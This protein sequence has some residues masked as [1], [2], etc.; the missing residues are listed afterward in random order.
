ML[1]KLTLIGVLGDNRTEI[2]RG[3]NKD[4]KQCYINS[5]VDEAHISDPSSCAE[6]LYNDHHKGPQYASVGR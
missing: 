1:Y 3:I 5:V 6:W 2:R 4:C